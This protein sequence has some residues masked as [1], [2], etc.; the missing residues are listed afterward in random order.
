MFGARQ[1]YQRREKPPSSKRIRREITRQTIEMSMDAIDYT[2]RY[3]QLT[4]GD[5]GLF[6][7]LFA[8][9]ES[10][11]MSMDGWMDGWMDG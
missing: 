7:L 8:S 6:S 9:L 3:I 4:V 2:E 11:R 1:V 10:L 5:E